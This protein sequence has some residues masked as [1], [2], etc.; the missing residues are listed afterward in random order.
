[1]NNV[2]A[3]P[4][5][6]VRFWRLAALLF[7]FSLAFQAS[8]ASFAYFANVSKSTRKRKK[9]TTTIKM[10]SKERQE[11]ARKGKE[12]GELCRCSNHIETILILRKK[13]CKGKDIE[14]RVWC[15]C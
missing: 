5:R 10:K 3:L 14:K 8:F 12:T 4:L 6:F 11:K 2:N 9:K 13:N 1:M 15:W 7:P